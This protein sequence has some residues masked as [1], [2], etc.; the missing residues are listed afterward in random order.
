MLLKICC[1][2]VVVTGNTHIGAGKWVGHSEAYNYGRWASAN[3]FNTI[4]FVFNHAHFSSMVASDS[5]G[6]LQHPRHH[7]RITAISLVT[8]TRTSHAHA[9]ALESWEKLHL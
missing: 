5:G 9:A 3:F 8:R 7:A 2:A 1:K 4:P 6:V